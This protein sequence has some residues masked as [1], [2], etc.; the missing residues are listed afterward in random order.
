MVTD[1]KEI[2]G[3]GD[4][5]VNGIDICVGK[6]AVYTGA[7]GIH[8]G[9]TIAVVAGLPV[10]TIRSAAQRPAAPRE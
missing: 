9:R 4:W 2:L 7:A 5:G 3:I 6:L 1:A 10:P 8:P